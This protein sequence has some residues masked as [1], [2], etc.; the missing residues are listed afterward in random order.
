MIIRR[1]QKNMIEISTHFN[2]YLSKIQEIRKKT[3]NKKIEKMKYFE[4]KNY[5][6][7]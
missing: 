2:T 3:K 4:A 7:Q 6:N 5:F 1:E